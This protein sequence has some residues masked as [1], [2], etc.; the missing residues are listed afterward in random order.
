MGSRK[1]KEKAEDIQL[2]FI[3]SHVKYNFLYHI[4][5]HV[6]NLNIKSIICCVYLG[7]WYLSRRSGLAL[8]FIFLS[9][10]ILTDFK[11]ARLRFFTQ[12]HLD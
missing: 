7:F 9:P 1:S 6:K 5:L 12:Y 8:G 2:F 11:K 4:F 3:F 10:N